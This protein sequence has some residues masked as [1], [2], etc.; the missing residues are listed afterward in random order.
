[1]HVFGAGLNLAAMQ[2]IHRELDPALVA[3]SPDV[4]CETEARALL[5]W[6]E[7]NT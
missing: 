4:P 6:L 1:M 7:R 2:S 3:Y 5:A